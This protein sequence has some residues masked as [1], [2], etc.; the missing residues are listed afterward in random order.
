MFC[1]GTIPC[2]TGQQPLK[3][4]PEGACSN[5]VK[6]KNDMGES[7]NACGSNTFSISIKA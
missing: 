1:I 5:F 2:C 7:Q 6:T 4:C 3:A